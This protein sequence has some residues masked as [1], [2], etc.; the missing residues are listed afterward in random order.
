MNSLRQYV[1][2]NI[3]VI[4]ILL[5]SVILAI[6]NY[7][8][9]TFLSGW[10]TLHP[11]FNF[12]L[13]FSREMVNGV[14]R[15]EQGLGAVAAHSHM[16]DLPRVIILYI[17]SPILP[18]AS[19]RYF[20]I[21]LNLILGPIGMYLFL[22][23]HV[24][25]NKTWSFLGAIFYLLNLGTLQTFIVPF[26]MFTTQYAALPWLFLFASNY[27][28]AKE[29]SKKQLLFFSIATLLAAPSAYAATLWYTYFFVFILYLFSLSYFEHSLLIFKKSLT[30]VSFTLLINLFW[31]LP[32]IY[33]VFNHASQV[34]NALINQLFSSQAFLYNKEFGNIRDISLLKNFLFD[35]N[36]YSGHN[37]F[38]L[39]L[40]PWI[41]YLSSIP[42][43][44]IGYIF[45]LTSLAGAFYGFSRKNKVLKSFTLP[46]LLCLFFLINNNPPTGF[47]YTFLQEKIPFFKEAFRFPG[48]K[49]L[50][51]FTFL[52]AIYFAQGQVLV[53][54]LIDL[55]YKHRPKRI[56]EFIQLA[57]FFLLIIIYMLPAFKGNLISQYMKIDIPKSYF[58]MFNW[59]DKQGD[60]RVVTLPINS[61]W[62][63][64]YY[65]WYD[66]KK[67]S[68]QGAGFLQFGI[69]QPLLDRDFDRWSPYNEQYYR[70]M[71]YAIYN[72]N[73]VLLE[74]ILKKYNVNYI[75]FDKS[76]LAPQENPTVLFFEDTQKILDNSPFLS[77]AF[78]SENLSVYQ[79]INKN[80]AV[81]MIK[82]PV[83]V[84]PSSLALYYDF[85]YLKYSDYITYPDKNAV[86][87]PYRNIIDNQNHLNKDVDCRILRSE[88]KILKM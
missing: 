22:N 64:I 59:F 4:A 52:F 13:N 43:Q 47:L 41:K 1:L 58:E 70:E 85:A 66:D 45:A 72:H 10:D 26:E 20:Y 48:D 82:N 2:N 49:I 38:T 34:P 12:G 50:G 55:A 3:A 15:V 24:V 46:L 29:K 71:S 40:S 87:Y 62:G 67:P 25:K 5:I 8:P 63:W 73:S 61:F 84:G 60:G 31:I 18:L 30:L 51:I 56:K 75:I 23:K 80:Q 57:L 42:M 88:I 11:E 86:F 74:T 37:S 44:F 7:T 79:L 9:G 35:W 68:F 28:F 27:L 39:L 21:F 33:Y 78:Q 6:V 81:R 69:K 17:L 54:R 36:V 77:K 19:L 83:N 14:F 53:Q 16:A 76:V 32:N 65:D